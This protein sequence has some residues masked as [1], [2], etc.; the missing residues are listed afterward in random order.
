MPQEPA[1]ANERSMDCE[2]TFASERAEATMAAANVRRRGMGSPER[3]SLQQIA[4]VIGVVVFRF[5][6]YTVD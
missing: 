5:H 3:I 6:P 4:A 2:A 1:Y